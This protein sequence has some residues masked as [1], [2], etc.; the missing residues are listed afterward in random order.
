[1]LIKAPAAVAG[2]KGSRS[3]VPLLW[4][5]TVRLHAITSGAAGATLFLFAVFGMA[6]SWRKN[7]LV[8]S[9]IATVAALAGGAAL[10]LGT[11]DV[12][13]FAFLFLA[14]AAAV[15]ASACL[16]HWLNERWL[17]ALAADLSVLLATW[18]VTN[19]LPEA[20]AAIPHLWLFGA[21]AALLA[22]YLAST[23]GTLLRGFNFTAFETAGRLRISDC[24]GRRLEPF[25][26]RRPA[27]AGHGNGGAVVRARVTWFPSR[28]SSGRPA[29]DST[30]RS[31]L[32]ALA[33]SS[34]HRDG[35]HWR[36]HLGRRPLRAADA[37]GPRS[38]LLLALACL[39]L[40]SRPPL[41]C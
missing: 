5:A 22:I 20:Y 15:E 26:R 11:H 30:R 29:R 18:L 14:I 21:Q 9:T 38:H 1:V 10:L 3:L 33:G 8:V 27:G 17:A 24:G 32:L 39:A 13:P 7:L 4:E 31:M 40:R 25:A 12:L 16:D 6:V 2:R 35:P 34:S 23:I 19:E 28:A 41:F 36:C 37:G